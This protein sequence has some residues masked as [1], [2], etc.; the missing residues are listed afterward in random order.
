M[1]VHISY[2]CGAVFVPSLQ[3][4]NTSRKGDWFIDILL[5]LIFVQ[6]LEFTS[7]PPLLTIQLKR[8]DFDLETLR[9][10]KINER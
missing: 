8:F 4:K 10:V 3:Y 2:T 9:R 1:L 5:F 6:G 7:F